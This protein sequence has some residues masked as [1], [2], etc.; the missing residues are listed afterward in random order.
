MTA[1]LL[2]IVG[3]VLLV[4]GAE[5]P[6]RG[7]SGLA[8]AIGIF[9]VLVGLTVVAYGT[10]RP[11]MAVSVMSD[12]TG[13]IRSHGVHQKI[14]GLIEFLPHHLGNPGGYGDD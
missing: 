3:L 6:V 2:L 10:S 9:P 14:I 11:E 13:K 7:A 1:V 4:A 8:S 12:H 5:T